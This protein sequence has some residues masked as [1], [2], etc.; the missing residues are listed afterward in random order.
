MNINPPKAPIN[1][2]PR[3]KLGYAGELG[4]GANIK[5]KFLQTAITREELDS[6]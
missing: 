2:Y 3:K 6:I 1:P 4:Q 5:I